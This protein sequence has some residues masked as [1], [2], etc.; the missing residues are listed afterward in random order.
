MGAV[1]N[2]LWVELKRATEAPA[3]Q[4]R[5]AQSPR[6]GPLRAA[7][8]V[9]DGGHRCP[10]RGG[11][12]AR[13]LGHPGPRD[14]PAA[15]G[16]GDSCHSG[17][18]VPA[19]QRRESPSRRR[20]GDRRNRRQPDDPAAGAAH[21]THSSDATGRHE[22]AVRDAGGGPGSAPG[23]TAQ[24]CTIGDHNPATHDAGER[25]GKASRRPEPSD[26]RYQ[27]HADAVRST[28]SVLP[29]GLV[30]PRSA[31]LHRLDDRC[32]SANDVATGISWI[33]GR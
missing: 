9:A 4:W 3:D 2:A 26:C 8:A 25:P 32:P 1:V 13:R 24:A 6:S 33:I 20:S 23:H 22:Y 31:R 5:I 10:G 27:R 16:A 14:G 17:C 11:D 19:S 21:Q 29:V 15:G 12:C 28:L 18:S 7:R 30:P